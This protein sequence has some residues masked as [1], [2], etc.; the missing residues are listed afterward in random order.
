FKEVHGSATGKFTDAAQEVTYVYTKNPTNPTNPINPT[1]PSVPG[2][3]GNNQPGSNVPINT[4]NNQPG[5]SNPEIT[6]KIQKVVLMHNAYM[7]NEAGQRT[8]AVTLKAGSF[9]DVYGNKKIND[10]LFYVLVDHGDNKK[11][12]YVATDN[13]EA[14]KRSLKH[15]AFIY[16]RYGKR[17]KHSKVLK[18]G[19]LVDTYG[20]PI[21]IRGH[22]YYIVAHNRFVKVANFPAAT[23]KAKKLIQGANEGNS[24]NLIEKNIMHNA[25]LY[26]KQGKRDNGVII[27]AGSKVKTTGKDKINGKTYYALPDG[28]YI[29]AGNIDGKKLRLKHNAYIYNQYGNRHGRKVLKKRRS[30]R[31]YG[32]AV[33][34]KHKQY[35]IVALNRYVKKANF[36]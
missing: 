5:S 26:N 18:K 27:A 2:I 8:N 17:V 29:A 23:A 3:P 13:V 6:D 16:N 10:R 20:D 25:Y 28:L 1:N 35:Y 24:V 15:N 14:T 30:V 19:Q 4:G 22:K 33:S 31:T 34:I 7:Y 36:K 9:L 11:K 12:Y 21:K 32:S